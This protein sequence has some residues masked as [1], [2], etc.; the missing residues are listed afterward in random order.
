MNIAIFGGSFDPVHIAHLQIVKEAKKNL[1]IEKIIIVPTY[2][3]PFK[4]DFYFNPQIRFKFLKKVFKKIKGVKVSDYEIKKNRA[5]YSIETVKYLK[6]KYRAKKIYFIIGADNLKNLKKWYKYEQLK[7]LVTFVVA[8][9]D[10]FKVK[11]S[12]NFIVMN[13]D[14]NISSTSLRES[15]DLN[16][17]PKEIK[18][19]II[20][21][22]KIKK[23]KNI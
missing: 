11:K 3:N 12:K 17:I 20:L 16:Y 9:R 13:I 21:I 22:Q 14:I 8:S 10:G 15:F 4:K 19:D 7:S 6:K 5:V 23:G 2:L 1:D 18:D